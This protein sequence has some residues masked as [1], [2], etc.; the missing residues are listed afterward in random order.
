MLADNDSLSR[1]LAALLIKWISVLVTPTNLSV[2]PSLLI[3]SLAAKEMV[4]VY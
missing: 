2:D 3:G 4:G 1:V